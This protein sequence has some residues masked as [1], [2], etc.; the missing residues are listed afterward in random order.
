MTR[1]AGF[2][3]LKRFPMTGILSNGKSRLTMIARKAKIIIVFKANANGVE[4]Y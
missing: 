1:F 4:R 3:F 2:Y